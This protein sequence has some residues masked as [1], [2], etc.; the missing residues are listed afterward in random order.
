[1]MGIY[2]MQSERR[3]AFLAN[4]AREHAKVIQERRDRFRYSVTSI[5]YSENEILSS[6]RAHADEDHLQATA[7][8]ARLTRKQLGSGEDIEA[9]TDG[10]DIEQAAEDFAERTDRMRDQDAYRRVQKKAVEY[11]GA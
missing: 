9:I 7:R 1:M 3:A 4:Y 2:Y 5:R 8:A 6:L 10:V 11:I